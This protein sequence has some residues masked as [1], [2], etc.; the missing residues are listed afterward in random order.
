MTTAK[1]KDSQNPNAHQFSKNAQAFRVINSTCST[2]RGNCRDQ[3]SAGIENT[4]L[5]R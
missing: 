3:K 5:R 4:P 2:I 1:R